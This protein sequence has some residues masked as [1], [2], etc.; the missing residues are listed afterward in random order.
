MFTSQKHPH[1]KT[2]LIILLIV[3]LS[4]LALYQIRS[5]SAPPTIKIG[6]VAPFEG[7]Y[8]STGYDVLFAVKL[9]LQ[10]RNQGQGLN[11]YRVELVALNDFNDPAEAR[12]Q[13][14]ALIADPDVVGVVGHLSSTTTL[15]AMPV[16][17]EARLAMS[18]PWSIDAAAFSDDSRGVVSVAATND[19]AIAHLETLS[20][21]M[22]LNTVTII[23]D[24]EVRS[25]PDQSQAIQLATDAVT[26]GNMVL[27]LSQ[28][29]ISLP[30]FGEVEVGAPQ[31]LQV[32]GAAAND[33]IFVSPG[34]GS[35]DI[36][37][38]S[39]FVEAYQALTGFPPAP[40]AVLAYDA[41]NVLLDSI[42]Q[43]MI[44][45]VV[46]RDGPPSRAEVSQMITSIQRQGVSG[47][48]IF[49]SR[50]QRLDAPVWVY[51][52]SEARYPG[53]LLVP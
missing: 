35:A 21:D 36:P 9:A 46:W 25:V 1:L 44:T 52:I 11:G 10:E 38:N 19:E 34:P 4:W 20:Q 8:R 18:I 6:L 22:G 3:L 48:I 24:A 14:Q 51:Q 31:L 33:L 26:A 16:Y 12:R 2:F 43:A 45:G 39:N 27:A 17:Q 28:S 32:A 13:A 23:T 53:T 7:L 37:A 41:T 30:L 42:E 5:S 15:A 50:G 40:R 47:K 49:D 29:D